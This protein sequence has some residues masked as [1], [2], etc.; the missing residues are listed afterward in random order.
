MGHVSIHWWKTGLMLI[1]TMSVLIGLG[2]LTIWSQQGS[3]NALLT[4]CILLQGT[5]FQRVYCVGHESAHR[6][7]FPQHPLL[8]NVVGQVFLWVLLVPLSIFRKIHDF[9]H[10]ANRRDARTSSLD[11]YIIPNNANWFQRTWPHL[12]WY[13]GIL[14]GG[15]FIHSL[16]SIL[17]F[18]ILPVRVAQ[19][20]SPAFKGWTLQDQI[21]SMICFVFPLAIHAIVLN[22][23]GLEYWLLC[24]LI[25]FGV[26]AVVYSLQLYIYHYR[27][28]MGKR[29]LFHARRLS[30]PKWISWW[31]LNLNEH[32]THHQRP[33]I[34]WYA[35]PDCH[36]N[37]PPEFAQNQNVHT[38]FEGVCQ[39]FK[40][41][42]LVQEN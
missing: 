2:V 10:S 32:D 25:P 22:R 31:L 17:L 3:H 41:P 35:L 7:L 37:L 30:G 21:Q 13:L 4:I 1:E 5:W 16:I 12:L 40:G 8:N 34:V 23:I 24:Y 27:T 19:K 15:W 18:L 39:Q 11:V 6:K 28:T 42:T 36:K 9:H 26:F 14:C 20:V 38:Y 29:T 33:K